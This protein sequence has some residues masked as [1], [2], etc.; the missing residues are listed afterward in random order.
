ME[1]LVFLQALLLLLV[2]LPQFR[3][4]LVEEGDRVLIGTA[5]FLHQVVDELIVEAVGDPGG[6]LR[7]AMLRS[8]GDDEAAP[9]GICEHV[10]QRLGRRGQV[11]PGRQVFEVR[12]L[13]ELDVVRSQRLD[14]LAAQAGA[15]QALDIRIDVNLRP[16]RLI[17]DLVH[18]HDLLRTLELHGRA[19]FIHRGLL[20][21]VVAHRQRHQERERQ[22]DPEAF[23]EDDVIV[24]QG[25]PLDDVFIAFA[26]RF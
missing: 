11:R 19:A 3:G 10:A 24:A 22:C 8:D 2:F 23:A 9:H 13:E 25:A 1:S 7:I 5:A 14:D 12:A 20:H 17:H 18:H 15:V 16:R 26:R 4:A 6:G 21:L